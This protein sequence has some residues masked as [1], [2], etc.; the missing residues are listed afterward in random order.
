MLN[1]LDDAHL[2]ALL[3]RA[4]FQRFGRAEKII[5]QGDDGASMFVLIRGEAKVLVNHNG[6]LT[7]VATLRASDCF[8]EMSLLTGEKRTATV[9]AQGECEI[10][11]IDKPMLADVVAEHPHLLQSL[12]ELLAKR[13]LE[14]EGI[15]AEAEHQQ[16]A[17]AKQTEYATTFL[18]K[19]RKVFEL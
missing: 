2:D 6:S 17:A 10:L 15:L 9:V 1:C 19:L 3:P 14:N 11:V 7:Q 8:G 16:A 4:R 18:H 5:E 12:S 13:R